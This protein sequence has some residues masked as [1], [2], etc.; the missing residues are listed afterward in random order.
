MCMRCSHDLQREQKAR[1]HKWTNRQCSQG[2]TIDKSDCIKPGWT[3]TRPNETT[4]MVQPKIN[5]TLWISC[6]CQLTWGDRPHTRGRFRKAVMG[7]SSTVQMNMALQKVSKCRHSAETDVF[8]LGHELVI[9]TQVK[10]EVYA[11]AIVYVDWFGWWVALRSQYPKYCPC[12]AVLP[13][14][15]S[16]LQQ[17]DCRC[18]MGLQWSDILL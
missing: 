11:C 18:L 9:E 16:H 5:S 13:Q 17:H 7:L 12:L 8:P 4:N 3:K 6:H 14:F 1:S 2:R 10:L 15:L